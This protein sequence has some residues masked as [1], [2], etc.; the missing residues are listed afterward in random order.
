MNLVCAYCGVRFPDRA[1]RS[2]GR[3]HAL[4]HRT[5]GVFAATLV[6]PIVGLIAGVLLVL[7]PGASRRSA[8]RLWLI[9]GLGSGGVHAIVWTWWLG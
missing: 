2:P 7:D 8:G 6:L 9:A 4:E 5:W 1:V 3:L